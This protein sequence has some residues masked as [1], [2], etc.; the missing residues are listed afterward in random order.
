MQ[1]SVFNSER[2]TE[3]I[4]SHLIQK[5]QQLDCQGQ[6]DSI[7][8]SEFRRIAQRTI[9]FKNMKHDAQ[10]T[11]LKGRTVCIQFFF[12]SKLMIAKG[13]KS[14]SSCPKCA[15]LPKHKQCVQRIDVE[16][17]KIDV[18][19]IGYGISK[20]DSNHRPQPIPVCL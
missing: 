4:Y 16:V 15:N 6:M 20:A 13:L 3:K 10:E 11:F 17:R 18:K 14:K 7:K 5:I 2:D 1:V 12:F 19:Y 9:Q 8:N